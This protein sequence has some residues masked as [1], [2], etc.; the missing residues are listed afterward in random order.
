MAK[1]SDA[2]DTE[3]QNHGGVHAASDTLGPLDLPTK[4]RV[5]I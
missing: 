2:D 5:K 4:V 1:T 3:Q